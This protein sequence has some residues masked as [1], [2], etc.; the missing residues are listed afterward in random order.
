MVGEGG[1]EE[2]GRRGGRMEEEGGWRG[3]RGEGEIGGGRV[4]GGGR[5]KES[6]GVRPTVGFDASYRKNGERGTAG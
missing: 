6:S 4:G 2:E 3:G 1:K 5:T